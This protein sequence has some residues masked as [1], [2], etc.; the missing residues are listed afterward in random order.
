M[1]SRV[2]RVGCGQDGAGRGDR[3][4]D[5]LL[6][7]EGINETKQIVSIIE[8][9]TVTLFNESVH[10][11]VTKNGAGSLREKPVEVTCNLHGL[12]RFRHRVDGLV[13]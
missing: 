10:L 3:G 13:R 4:G 12:L 1:A 9:V 6:S 7:T 2:W 11:N 8:N 5:Q